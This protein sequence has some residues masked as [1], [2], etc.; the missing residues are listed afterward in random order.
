MPSPA[1]TTL[2]L[3]ATE[4]LMMNTVDDIIIL[5]IAELPA[6]RLPRPPRDGLLAL[7]L[8]IHAGHGCSYANNLH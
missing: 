4:T 8:L 7:A 2:R 5:I 6:L 3:R 1:A